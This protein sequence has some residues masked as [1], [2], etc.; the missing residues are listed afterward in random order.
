MSA[1]LQTWF[2][3]PIHIDLNGREWRTISLDVLRQPVGK[4]CS[5]EK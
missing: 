3:F 4:N 5:R 1:R 2:P